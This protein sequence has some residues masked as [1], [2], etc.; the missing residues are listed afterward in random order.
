MVLG[1]SFISSRNAEAS[2]VFAR[3]EEGFGF[4]SVLCGSWLHEAHSSLAAMDIYEM[5]E[6]GDS[7]Q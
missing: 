3:M 7:I 6:G 4:R 1:S 2:S 5:G